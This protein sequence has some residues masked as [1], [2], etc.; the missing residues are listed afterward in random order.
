MVMEHQPNT[1]ECPGAVSGAYAPWHLL[2]IPLGLEAFPA[3]WEMANNERLVLLALLQS[4]QPPVAIEIGTHFGGSLAAIKAFAGKVYSLDLDPTCR[5]RLAASSPNVEFLTGCSHRT[6]PPLIERLNEERAELG[7]VLVDGDHSAAGA[8]ADVEAVLQ[9][10]PTRPLF[11]LMHD[12]FN[13]DVRGGLRA[14]AWE[15]ARHVHLVELDLVA[16]ICCRRGIPAP[17]MWGGL[18][19]AILLPEPRLA[20]LPIHGSSQLLFDTL[21]PAS[22]HV[23]PGLLTRLHRGLR[24]VARRILRR[25]RRAA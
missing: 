14:V 22:S 23:A 18:A 5:D 11:V 3:T 12:S 2:N 15:A 8:R 21:L 1:A 13:P 25:N 20:P 9:F 17:A 6:L 4:L 16:G 10:R 19:V 24:R 7:F